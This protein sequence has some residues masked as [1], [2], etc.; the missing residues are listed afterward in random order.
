MTKEST[1]VVLRKESK[2][3][4]IIA[5]LGLCRTLKGTHIIKELI[6]GKK[7]MKLLTDS[8]IEQIVDSW[9]SRYCIPI[10]L[11]DQKKNLDDISLVKKAEET[12]K[13][14]RRR[15]VILIGDYIKMMCG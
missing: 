7:S 2:A 15:K 14:Y 12:E 13:D 4:G 10:V 5:Q 11:L 8:E 9:E 1:N 6:T 3:R